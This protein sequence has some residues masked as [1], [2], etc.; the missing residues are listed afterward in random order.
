MKH[1]SILKH[2]EQE[3]NFFAA[4]IMLFTILFIALVFILDLLKIFIVPINT[5]AIACGAATLLL[6]V[7]TVLVKLLKLRHPVIKYITVTSA[8]LMVAIMNIF[9]SYHVILLFMFPAA[10][11]SLFFS[12]KVSWY[13]AG[14]T[15]VCTVGSQV[16]NF[17]YG[18]VG[19]RNLKTLFEVMVYGVAPRSIELIA[20]SVIFI[21][22]SV[23]TRAML[24]N[25]MGAEEQA[26]LLEKMKQ[27]GNRAME[28][29]AQLSES[30]SQLSVITVETTASNE[31]IAENTAHL[32]EGS[33]DSHRFANAATARVDNMSE[34]LKG[35]AGESRNIADI[36]RKLVEINNDSGEKIRQTVEKMKGIAEASEGS[37]QFIR[38]LET[39]SSQIRSIVEV[40]TGIS[41]QTNLLALNAAIESARAGEQGRGFA[42]VAD[43][44][45]KLAEQSQNASKNI[46]D[47]ISQV[48]ED[49]GKT[50][51]AVAH[52]AIMAESGVMAVEAAGQAFHSAATA[53]RS[54]NTRVEE[55]SQLTESAAED[56]AQVSEG[57]HHIREI[58]RSMLEEIKIIASAAEQQVASMEQVSAAVEAIGKLSEDLTRPFGDEGGNN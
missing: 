48:L 45:R 37:K 17:L 23:R 27:S 24:Q 22:L 21:L 47:L 46:A 10:I 28:V 36:S 55:V 33:E 26:G 9:L 32:A 16:L 5:M 44:I 7:P 20:L 3:A 40:I 13:T 15:L 35:I 50:A 6:A 41:E 14:L 34:K 57:V 42:V 51:Q 25:V 29:S 19:D 30:V 18:D 58:N 52:S 53:G 43:E 4:R 11:A 31:Q 56:G 54:L 49:T 2:N 38:L 12:R 8:T 1:N 39:K